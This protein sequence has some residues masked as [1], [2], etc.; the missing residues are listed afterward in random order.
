M[1]LYS[2]V[3]EEDMILLRELSQQQKNQRAPKIKNRILKQTHDIKLAANLSPITKKLEEDNETIK[4]LG[5]VTEKSQAEK[6]VSQPAIE[7]TPLS[8][9]RENNECVIYDTEL[10]NTLKNMKNN[11]GFFKHMK[12]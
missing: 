12:I 11:S 6:N 5:G 8:Q 9:Q 1:S 10:E 3:T 7:H 4:N 2:N